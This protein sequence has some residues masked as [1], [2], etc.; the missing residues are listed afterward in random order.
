MKTLAI[1]REHEVFTDRIPVTD[2]SYS[3]ERRAVRVF[4]FD[5]NENVA[6]LYYPPCETRVK[7][8][9][10]LI[11][12]GIENN[13]TFEEALHREV[14]EEAGCM[15]H[16]IEEIGHIKQYGI[17]SENKRIQ[18]E[19]FYKAY[20]KGDKGV[21]NFDEREQRDG[22]EIHWVPLEKLIE[23]LEG[24]RPSFGRLAALMIFRNY[25]A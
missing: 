16:S 17:G 9:Y 25:L 8:E 21:P 24:Q 15:I 22:V 23:V 4:L 1:I 18:D 3:C 14:R 7:G 10:L 19:Y 6:V 11:G 13:E 20:I 5:E 12:G 2:E